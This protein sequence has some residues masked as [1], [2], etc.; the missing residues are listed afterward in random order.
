MFIEKIKNAVIPTNDY[1]FKRIFGHVGNEDITIGLLNS[2]IDTKVE[3]IQLDSN[4]ITEKD[5][6]DEKLGI[7]DIK[8][9]LNDQNPCDIEMQVVEQVNILERILLY[10]SKL[11]SSQIKQGETYKKLHKTISILIANFEFDTLQNIPKFHTE[12]K[13][14]EKECV[15]FLLA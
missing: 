5:M 8:A 11:Y 4:P 14:R 1:V 2:I 13:I 9:V 15:K 3:K 12:W 10:W 7:L 6:L